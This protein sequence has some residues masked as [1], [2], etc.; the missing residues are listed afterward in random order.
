MFVWAP[1]PASYAD[2]DA[3]A[4]DLLNKT[5]LVVTP[6][7]RFGKEGQRFVRIALVEDD[8][9]IEEAARRI[10][11]FFEKLAQEEDQKLAA[12]KKPASDKQ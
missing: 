5:G 2:A 10:A 1:I 6:G 4:H 11:P 3:F 8:A 9:A 7:T 12:E